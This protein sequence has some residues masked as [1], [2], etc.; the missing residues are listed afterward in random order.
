M[1]PTI[2]IR[3]KYTHNSLKDSTPDDKLLL[4]NVR[5][6]NCNSSHTG[7]N[8]ITKVDGLWYKITGNT[9]VNNVAHTILVQVHSKLLITR[10]THT[11]NLRNCR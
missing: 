7:S 10:P 3:C 4:T 2:R 6:R 11:L 5:E 8:I 9:I 1:K